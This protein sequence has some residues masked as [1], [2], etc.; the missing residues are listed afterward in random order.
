MREIILINLKV[1]MRSSP[2]PSSFFPLFLLCWEYEEEWLVGGSRSFI[3]YLGVAMASLARISG[4]ER[5]LDLGI[6]GKKWD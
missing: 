3:G 4:W 1:K 5:L 6:G 2:Q